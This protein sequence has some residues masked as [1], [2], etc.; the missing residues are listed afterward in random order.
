MTFHFYL[1][2]STFVAN[3]KRKRMT[4]P[5]QSHNCI[6]AVPTEEGDGTKGIMNSITTGGPSTRMVDIILISGTSE[7]QHRYSVNAAM[8][9]V[10]LL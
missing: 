6:I 9:L 1:S 5:L 10:I 3:Q 2:T 7:H 4:I 8:T